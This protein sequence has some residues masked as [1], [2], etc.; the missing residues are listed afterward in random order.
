MLLTDADGVVDYSGET[1][2]VIVECT[3]ED[4]EI[5]LNQ[6]GDYQAD[7]VYNIKWSKNKVNC[8]EVLDVDAE[9]L[10]DFTL[11]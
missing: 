5:R 10:L 9:S 8:E 4:V 1:G 3:D 7:G 11:I 6:L 2:Y